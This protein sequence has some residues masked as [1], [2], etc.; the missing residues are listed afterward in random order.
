MNIKHIL[1]TR[2]LC[3]NFKEIGDDKLL[4]NE[5]VEYH[6]NLLKNNLLRS[7]SAQTTKNFELVILIHK[8]LKQYNPI[9]FEKLNKLKYEFHI[10]PMFVS[11]LRD[12]SY[13]FYQYYDR[14]ITSRIDLDDF[15]SHSAIEQLQK[16]SESVQKICLYGFRDGFVTVS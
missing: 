12:Y 15:I 14:V 6:F 10:T 7:L 16:Y 4:S 1:I 8:K 9:I 11:D 3:T 13:T 2:F 5:N